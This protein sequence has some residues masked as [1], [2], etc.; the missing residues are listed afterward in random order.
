MPT[1][2]IAFPVIDPVALQ[3]KGLR[4]GHA[5]QHLALG[6]IE[7]GGGLQALDDTGQGRSNDPLLRVG[8]ADDGGKPDSSGVAWRIQGTGDDAQCGALCR[9]KGNEV[10][11]GCSNCGKETRG[12]QD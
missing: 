5:H 4:A 1:F 8:N 10:C 2:A 12:N 6:H 9:G 11:S 7:P 3:L